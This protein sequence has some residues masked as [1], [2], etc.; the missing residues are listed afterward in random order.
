MG[1]T[2]TPSLS[3]PLSLIVLFSLTRGDS[4]FIAPYQKLVTMTEVTMYQQ[5]KKYRHDACP[6]LSL[7]FR[8]PQTNFAPLH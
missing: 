6:P 5:Y 2:L 7:T 1:V 3:L 8:V 4:Q